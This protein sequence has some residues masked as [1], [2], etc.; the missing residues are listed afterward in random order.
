ME[1]ACQSV[2]KTQEMALSRVKN[3]PLQLPWTLHLWHLHNLLEDSQIFSW[4][5]Y[6][7]DCHRN[8]D[9]WSFELWIFFCVGVCVCVCVL[10]IHRTTSTPLPPRPTSYPW[11]QDFQITSPVLKHLTS[12]GTLSPS[13]NLAS[14]ADILRGSSWNAWQT[15]KDICQGGYIQS[16]SGPVFLSYQS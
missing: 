10:P 7:I 8:A 16:Y 6:I 14:P 15:P 9:L 3:S 2:F 13:S 4:I 1:N 11:A 5:W 12:T